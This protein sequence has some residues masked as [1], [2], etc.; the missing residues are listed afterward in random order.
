MVA[1]AGG[2]GVQ[3]A[4][5]SGDFVGEAA[6]GAAAGGAISAFFDRGAGRWGCGRGWCGRSRYAGIAAKVTAAQR[7]LGAVEGAGGGHP[8]LALVIKGAE[9][10]DE[11]LWEQTCGKSAGAI[12]SL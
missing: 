1:Y 8:A 5:E 6:E 7:A 4:A 2:E 9:P 10:G 11:A 3:V 12:N